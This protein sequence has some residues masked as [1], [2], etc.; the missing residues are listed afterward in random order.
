MLSETIITMGNRLLFGRE[1]VSL[2]ERPFFESLLN[3]LKPI[4]KNFF[5]SNFKSA[6]HQRFKVLYFQKP[7]LPAGNPEGGNTDRKNYKRYRYEYG[8]TVDPVV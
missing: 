7:V 2:V 3:R 1:I 5:T 8:I 6:L 4:S